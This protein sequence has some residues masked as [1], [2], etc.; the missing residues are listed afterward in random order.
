MASSVGTTDGRPNRV[1]VWSTGGIGSISIV[2]AGE[3][4]DLELVGVWVHSHDKVG[5]DSGELANGQPNGVLATNDVDALIGLR[6]DCVI[7]AA[8]GDDRDA[9]AIPDYVRLLEAGINVVTTT[10]TQMVN[11]KAYH[12]GFAEQLRTAAA[13][14]GASIYASGIE[15]G[16]VL[17][18]LPLVLTTASRSV[19]K[20]HLYELALYDDYGVEEIM[21]NA[22]GFGRPLEYEAWA[23]SPGGIASEYQG[24]IRM[25]AEG[26]GVEVDDVR[27]TF[28]RRVTDQAIETEFGAVEPGTCGA[29]RFQA[30]GVVD[31]QDAIVIDHVTRLARHVAP[32]WPI[33]DSDLAYKIEITGKPNLECWVSPTLDDPAEAGIP[34]MKSG[35]GAM[36]ATAMRVVNAV[37]Y[38]VDAE[39]GML[40]SLELPITLPRHAMRLG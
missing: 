27:D 33:G 8:S 31:G 25:I 38:V 2:V 20:L 39:P 24:Q 22:L 16:F 14:G 36:L 34:W 9:G 12:P 15:P 35:A 7:H 4:P 32:D 5:K 19:E 3:R 40:R 21:V 18:Q 10:A 6:P 30:I 13:K 17:D 1:V 23:A 29:I 37:P 11:P 26:L 28:D